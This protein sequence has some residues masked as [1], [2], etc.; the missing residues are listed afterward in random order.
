M[1]L[2]LTTPDNFIEMSL[3][4]RYIPSKYN[5]VEIRDFKRHLSKVGFE[6][7]WRPAALA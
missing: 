2:F 1:H 6:V 7:K 5:V 3:V 4:P